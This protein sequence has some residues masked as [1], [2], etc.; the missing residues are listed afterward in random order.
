MNLERIEEIINLVKSND[1]K[2]LNIKT[3]RMK[4]NLISQ[5][6][7]HHK[8]Y[9]KLQMYNQMKWHKLIMKL[10]ILTTKRKILVMT[11]KL[12]LLWL[13]RFLTR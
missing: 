2:S 5:R 9:L 1:V 4:L 3:L 7:I 12:N 8:V 6:V 13:V 11:K 10:K